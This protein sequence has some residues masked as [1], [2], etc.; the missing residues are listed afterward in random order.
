MATL[1]VLKRTL[2]QKATETASSF[3]IQPLSDTQYSAGL[4]IVQD[5]GWLTYRDFIIPQLSLLIASRINSRTYISA[6]EIGPGPKSVLGY[7]PDYVRRSVGRY[8]AFEP[9]DLFATRLEE[10]VC[11]VPETESP[12]PCLQSPPDIR[13]APF[14]LDNN[15]K[16]DTSTGTVDGVEKFDII[17]FCHSMYGMKRKRSFI[18]QALEM[19]VERPKGGIVVVF[20]RDG[21]LHFD[22]LVCHRTASFPTGA[23]RVADD[24][25]VLDRFAPFVAG[26][27]MQDVGV[28][29][30]IRLE[31][32]AIGGEWG[33]DD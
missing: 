23:I 31:W 33:H 25:E 24:D 2:R 6:L 8:V 10:W 21:S 5:S 30:T 1:D 27:V 14:V 4:D 20:H 17:L 26:F 13:H 15:T 18:E 3:P 32:R 28:D 22:G 7:L 29:K 11:S 16:S 9:N 19:L 12:L